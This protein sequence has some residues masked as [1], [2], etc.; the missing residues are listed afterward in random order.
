MK[1]HRSLYILA[2]VVV[3]FLTGF[4]F[5]DCQYELKYDTNNDCRFD[6]YDLS[7]LAN[8]WLIDCNLDPVVDFCT[9]QDRDNDGFN[10]LDDCNDNDPNIHPGA[11]EL[12][13][14]IDNNCNAQIDEG[15]AGLGESAQPFQL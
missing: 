11:T 9:P 5:A 6:I 15:F 7:E 10:F 12:C 1:K 3:I 4:S 13:D 2:I 14:G 8:V